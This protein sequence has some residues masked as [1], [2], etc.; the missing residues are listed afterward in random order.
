[1]TSSSSEAARAG[2]CGAIEVVASQR[3]VLSRSICSRAVPGL[4]A[5]TLREACS[6]ACAADWGGCGCDWVVLGLTIPLACCNVRWLS[7]G[8][9]CGICWG[10]LSIAFVSSFRCGCGCGWGCMSECDCVTVVMGV[11]AMLGLLWTV[12]FAV[13]PSAV[14]LT[15][16][17]FRISGCSASPLA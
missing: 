2:R 10:C 5:G 4:S 1:M 15:V 17:G 7:E 14:G 16:L 3:T 12:A 11:S 8:T 13:I 6:S 9:C